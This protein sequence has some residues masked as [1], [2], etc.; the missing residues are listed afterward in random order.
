[1]HYE[2]D[3]S[4]ADLQYQKMLLSSIS[5]KGNRHGDLSKIIHKARQAHQEQ[6]PLWCSHKTE[7]GNTVTS[8]SQK[9]QSLF[10]S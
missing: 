2:M 7:A 8:L 3:M 10:R 1:M 4:E 5:I 9:L 6:N